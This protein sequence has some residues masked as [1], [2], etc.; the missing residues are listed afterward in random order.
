MDQPDTG[1]KMWLHSQLWDL[2]IFA[3][4]TSQVMVQTVARRDGLRMGRYTTFPADRL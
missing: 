3:G 2:E 1:T 4:W